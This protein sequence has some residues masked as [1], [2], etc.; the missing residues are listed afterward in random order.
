MP[1]GVYARTPEYRAKMRHAHRDKS[2]HLLG[3]PLRF[4]QKVNALP[5]GC[6]E[7]I[8]AKSRGYGLF[9]VGSRTDGTY[10]M[11]PAHRLAYEMLVGPIPDGLE[12]DHLCRNRP[13]V[14]PD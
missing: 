3:L 10:R 9:R 7:W 5:N 11:V 2:P 14:R 4:W 12:S 8:A 13:C 6:W 1:R